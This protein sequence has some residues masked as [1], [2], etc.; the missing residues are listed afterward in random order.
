M[1]GCRRT[2]EL[3]RHPGT[4]LPDWNGKSQGNRF[5]ENLYQWPVVFSP[6]FVLPYHVAA[7]YNS[8]IHF[9]DQ[10]QYRRILSLSIAIPSE[11]RELKDLFSAFAKASKAEIA[12]RQI[13]TREKT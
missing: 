3:T 6:S 5:F 12:L 10:A 2:R 13:A 11:R 1:V 9:P 4:N 7:F 8:S